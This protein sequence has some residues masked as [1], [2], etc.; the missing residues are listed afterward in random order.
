[1]SQAALFALAGLQWGGLG[2]ALAL[3]GLFAAGMILTDTLG[4][5][6]IARLIA[7]ADQ[8]AI[9]ASRVMGLAVAGVSLL[10][11]G[12]AASHSLLPALD[13]RLAGSELL[14]GAVVCALMAASYALARR[15][16]RSQVVEGGTA[17]R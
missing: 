7:R 5:L 12:L 15:L 17:G 10:V 6:W 1:V 14:P 13:A 4:G 9:I 3:A 16:A 2:H 8:L 11:A